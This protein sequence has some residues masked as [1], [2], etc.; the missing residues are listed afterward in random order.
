MPGNGLHDKRGLKSAS[1]QR[2]PGNAERR[3][4]PNRHPRWLQHE[5]CQQAL[6]KAKNKGVT[7][8]Q[9]CPWISNNLKALDDLGKS[10]KNKK[11]WFFYSIQ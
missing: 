5:P 9:A 3:R 4:R 10:V 8:G 11:K 2:E 7:G 1:A 6:E